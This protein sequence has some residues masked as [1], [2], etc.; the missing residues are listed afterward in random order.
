[1]L[2]G[3]A[4]ANPTLVQQIEARVRNTT[5]NRVRDLLVEQADGG[6]VL[7]GLVRTRHT[8]QLALHAALE[9]LPGGSLRDQ[10]VVR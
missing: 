5:C 8:K 6:V 7:R 1:M 2:L 9:L 3:T 4:S 10:I